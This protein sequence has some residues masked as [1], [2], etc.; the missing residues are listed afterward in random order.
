VVDEPALAVALQQRIIAGAG[1]DVYENE[2]RVNPLLLTLENVVLTPHI[3]SASV[4]TR[5]KMS[6]MA[7]ENAVAAI[8]GRRPPNLLNPEAW[9]AEKG[10]KPG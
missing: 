9:V 7:A 4:D 5:R 2:P 1:I 3:A 8:E 6:M 10:N